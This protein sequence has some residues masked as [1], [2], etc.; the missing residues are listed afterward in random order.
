VAVDGR[1][2]L[3]GSAA[4]SRLPGARDA[5]VATNYLGVGLGGGLTLGP[6]ARGAMVVG[7]LM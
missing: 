2:M 7:C 1:T 5:T 6:T 4:T 3:R